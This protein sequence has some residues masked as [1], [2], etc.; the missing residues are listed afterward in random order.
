MIS[1]SDIIDSSHFD[2]SN[3]HSIRD[4][5]LTLRP[6][7]INSPHFDTSN[8][9]SICDLTLTLKQARKAD[10]G[11]WVNIDEIQAKEA[12]RFFM[13]LLNDAVY[14]KAARRHAKR[15][16]VLPIL[17]RDHQG[18]WHVHAAIELPPNICPLQF[19]HLIRECW[20]RVDW[21]H[22][23]IFARDNADSGWLD[24]MLKAR[25]KSGLEAWSDCI[26]W[27]CCINP[28]AGA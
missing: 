25:Q 19:D 17:E 18:R 26:V 15:L 21:G 3:R 11:A 12:F 9:H 20:S 8:W 4:R 28:I 14:G 7:I 24:Y 16:K 1:R 13:R 22:D 23:L 5:T 6:D 2:T 27:E 10:N